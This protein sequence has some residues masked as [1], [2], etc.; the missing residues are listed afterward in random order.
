MMCANSNCNR[1]VLAWL[2]HHLGHTYID[3]QRQ[4]KNLYETLNKY[5]RC[6]L[7]MRETRAERCV[8][9]LRCTSEQRRRHVQSQSQTTRAAPPEIR[10]GHAASSFAAQWCGMC[11]MRASAPHILP[12]IA[13]YRYY[14]CISDLSASIIYMVI[15]QMCV[16]WYGNIV[17][18][19][20]S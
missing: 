10:Q 2:T 14:K 5:V 11:S 4:Q 3:Q 8:V 1:L 18:I 6:F 17:V 20:G 16:Y 19:G 7:N 9:L 15:L 12:M 13:V